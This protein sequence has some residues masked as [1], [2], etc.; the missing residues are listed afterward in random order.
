MPY[1]WSD[2]NGTQ[3]LDLWAHNSL[4]ARGFVLF[5]AVTAG[6]FLLPLVAVLGSPVLWGILPF[7][8]IALAAAWWAMERNRA[9]RQMTEVLTITADKITL[10]RTD[11]S[12]Q[13]H[14]QANPYWIRV[15]C[16]PK[17]GPVE[18]YLTLEGGPRRV[19]IGAFLTAE[20][21]QILEGEL[22]EALTR[23]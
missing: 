14:W 7:M 17:S 4:P 19:E 10:M 1:E 16:D 11:K 5:I 20:E 6:L 12:G 21:R 18:H 23:T 9:D 13:R 2:E 3:K 8:L 15:A 22:R